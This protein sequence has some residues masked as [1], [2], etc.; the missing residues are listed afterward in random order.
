MSVSGPDIAMNILAFDGHQHVCSQEPWLCG[1]YCANKQATHKIGPPHYEWKGAPI[2]PIQVDHRW[3]GFP[4]WSCSAVKLE[5][6]VTDSC[7]QMLDAR[8]SRADNNDFIDFNHTN[9]QQ[10]SNRYDNNDMHRRTEE[11]PIIEYAQ[12]RN[13]RHQQHG[14]HDFHKTFSYSLQQE[15]DHLDALR[16]EV[17]NICMEKVVATK[18]EY[19]HPAHWFRQNINSP[20]TDLTET[21]TIDI[22]KTPPKEGKMRKFWKHIVNWKRRKS[23]GSKS[24]GIHGQS[25]RYDRRSSSY[26]VDGKAQL[27]GLQ[28]AF[29]EVI[30]NGTDY[31]WKLKQLQSIRKSLL[32]IK[33]DGMKDKIEI[34]NR[35]IIKE[36]KSEK[37]KQ[38]TRQQWGQNCIKS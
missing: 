21:Y 25:S 8:P 5:S 36:I 2:Q 19:P 10:Y 17:L 37:R 4:K 7:Q 34:L 1:V 31:R 13:D 9:R 6:E 12:S 32:R 35:R 14:L 24:H 22:P 26:L 27:A 20:N 15:L 29:N 33:A 11:P 23:S 18:H 16:N 30:E 38:E 3:N 28:L